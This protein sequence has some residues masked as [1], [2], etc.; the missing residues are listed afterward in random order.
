MAAV[1]HLGDLIDALAPVAA[2][3]AVVRRSTCPN[4]A[5][6]SWTGTPASRRWV[7]Q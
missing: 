2:S 7:A 1:K 5:E 3:R 6:T 4:R